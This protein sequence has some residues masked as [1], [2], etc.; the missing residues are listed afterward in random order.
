MASGLAS[1]RARRRRM[2]TAP[3]PG[4]A[5]RAAGRM[6][7][8]AGAN[9]AV[10]LVAPPGPGRRDRASRSVRPGSAPFF[11]VRAPPRAH[12]APP[13]TS[14]A[15]ASPAARLR[16]SPSAPRRIDEARRALNADL[17]DFARAA[18]T[19][20]R[21]GPPPPA[22]HG[23]AVRA[24]RSGRGRRVRGRAGGFRRSDAAGRRA[25]PSAR[26]ARRRPLW[27]PCWPR[28]SRRP[29]PPRRAPARS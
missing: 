25:R 19:P 3:E 28:Q 13:A 10:A 21:A 12:H 9:R 23:R 8:A 18:L 24:A 22:A 14:P 20:A 26:R 17:P 7:L 6:S 27:P 5:A 29:R 15:A 1:R 16:S 11:P 4:W 2:G